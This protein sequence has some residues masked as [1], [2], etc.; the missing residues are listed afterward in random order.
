MG[1]SKVLLPW[2]GRSI[3]RQIAEVTLAARFETVLLVTGY[4][5][6]EV[7]AAVRGLSIR[8]VHNTEYEQGLSTSIRAGVRALPSTVYAATIILGDQPLLF[9]AVLDRIIQTYLETQAAIVVPFAGRRRGN[10]VLFD[11]SLFPRLLALE[12][13]DGARAIVDAYGDKVARVEVDPL[14]FEDV[15]TPEAYR[16]LL[17]LQQ[18][19]NERVTEET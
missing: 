11:R 4:R 10:P 7:A 6:P 15:D 3:I 1:A 5:A 13:D 12:G 2:Q 16:R 18:A 19:P 14:I 9:P 8:I 17:E